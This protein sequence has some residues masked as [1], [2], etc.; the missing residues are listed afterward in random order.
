MPSYVKF[1]KDILSNK[2]NLEKLKTIALIEN[3]SVIFQ[4]KLPPKLKDLRSCCIPCT[5]GKCNFEKALGDLG[6]SVNLMPLS[7]Y[8]KLRFGELK[9]IIVSLLLVDCFIKHP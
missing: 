2:R 7:T 6:A 4:K 3:C 5:I 1:M 8:R 9:L